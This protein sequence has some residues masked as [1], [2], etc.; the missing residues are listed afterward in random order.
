M[1]R[2]IAELYLY[3]LLIR[4]ENG[5]RHSGIAVTTVL[6]CWGYFDWWVYDA[7]EIEIRLWVHASY[8][9][10]RPYQDVW[11]WERCSLTVWSCSR[12]LPL[13]WQAWSW[14]TFS[15]APSSESWL[16][17]MCWSAQFRHQKR[18]RF[19]HELFKVQKIE[20]CWLLLLETRTSPLGLDAR[21]AAWPRRSITSSLVLVGGS[22]IVKF[23]WVL[24]SLHPA[25][26]L[27]LQN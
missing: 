22:R 9:S 3:I 11:T 10:I 24:S 6:C 21:L 18:R 1:E 12:S 4:P 5:A 2:S 13:A 7:G 17:V 20:D 25:A 27:L 23:S 26:G 15:A 16:G 8:R 19:T 14:M